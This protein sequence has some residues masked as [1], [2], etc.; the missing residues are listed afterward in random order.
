MSWYKTNLGMLVRLCWLLCDQTAV[1]VKKMIPIQLQPVNL[2]YVIYVKSINCRLCYP[3]NLFPEVPLRHSDIGKF[4][5]IVIHTSNNFQLMSKL[6]RI[7]LERCVMVFIILN[8]IVIHTLNNFQLMSKLSCL[9]RELCDG[10]Y[11]SKK[12]IVYSF[13]IRV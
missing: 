9:F 10:V 2:K 11:H 4:N 13:L 1:I 7:C 3:T 8:C 5:C 6:S 12:V